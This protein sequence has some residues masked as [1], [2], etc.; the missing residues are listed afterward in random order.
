[1]EDWAENGTEPDATKGG[2]EDG[3]RKMKTEEDECRRMRTECS[4]L[5]SELGTWNLELGTWN[6]ELGIA[7]ST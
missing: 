7:Q 4:D 6:L 2:Q 3:G 1:V 5:G